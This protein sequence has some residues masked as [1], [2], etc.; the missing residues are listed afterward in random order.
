MKYVF[1]GIVIVVVLAV[2]VVVG[3]VYWFSTTTVDF[4][5]PQL[6]GKFGETYAKNCVG[7]YEKQ[8]TKAG[9]PPTSEQLVAAEAACKCA[10]DPVI[11]ALAKRPKMTV[12]ELAG[13]MAADPEIR[14][15]TKTCS[16]AAGLTVP[17]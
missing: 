13:I 8:L 3:G 2:V 5:D 17:Q 4:N 9:T 14:T 15:I 7:T 1:W 16:E 6:V 12:S 10:R 11:A